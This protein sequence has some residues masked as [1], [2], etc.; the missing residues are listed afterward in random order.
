MSEINGLNI[1]KFTVS[2]ALKRAIAVRRLSK[3][4]AARIG[5]LSPA[6]I[7]RFM[8][9]ERGLSG[10]SIDDLAAGLGLQ[11]VDADLIEKAMAFALDC[12]SPERREAAEEGFR[13]LRMFCKAASQG[14]HPNVTS[15][16]LTPNVQIVELADDSVNPQL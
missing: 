11:L 4:E 3:S 14:I 1:E 13:M 5:G 6:M 15:P 16:G 7:G 10:E 2:E 9:G 8:S 12:L